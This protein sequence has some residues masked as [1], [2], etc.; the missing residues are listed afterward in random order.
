[1][2]DQLSIFFRTTL[3]KGQD[4]ITLAEEESHVRSYLEIQQFRYS[5]ILEYEVEMDPEIGTYYILKICL[6]PI[7]E[8]ALYHGI[9]NKREKGKLTVKGWRRGNYLHFLC[10]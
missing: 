7:V 8:N 9:K 1:M 10:P 5:D 6:Q 3:S 4:F 2:V